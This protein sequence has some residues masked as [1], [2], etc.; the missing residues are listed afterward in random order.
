MLAKVNLH[1]MVVCTVGCLDCKLEHLW[2]ET[3]KDVYQFD[4]EPNVKVLCVEIF[5]LWTNN[6]EGPVHDEVSDDRLEF[7]HLSK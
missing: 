4:M 1:Y 6:L 3:C 7:W 5:Q 2:S